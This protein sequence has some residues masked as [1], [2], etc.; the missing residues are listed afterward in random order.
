MISSNSTENLLISANNITFQSNP[1]FSLSQSTEV[2]TTNIK[3]QQKCDF[4]INEKYKTFNA[5]KEALRTLDYS[6]KTALQVFSR[7]RDITS[8]NENPQ[9][10]E[11]QFYAEAAE[12]LPSIAKNV[13]EIAKLA[14]SCGLDKTDIPGFEPL[15]DKC[16]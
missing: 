6:S 15:M 3:D 12:M 4:I 8:T 14:T 1:R 13:H 10:F 2:K 9:G 7:L 16:G 5:C 11:A